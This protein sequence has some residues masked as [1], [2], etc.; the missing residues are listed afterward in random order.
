MRLLLR[1][2][3]YAGQYLFIVVIKYGFIDKWNGNTN[4]RE[5]IIKPVIVAS[6]L[7]LNTFLDQH[8]LYNPM[9]QSKPGF[10]TKWQ[11]FV[12]RNATIHIQAAQPPPPPPQKSI[13]YTPGTA[14]HSNWLQICHLL[15]DWLEALVWIAPH[16]PTEW[17]CWG[18]PRLNSSLPECLHFGK[19]YTHHTHTH[20]PHTLSAL[21]TV[22]FS[23]VLFHS[24]NLIYVS[25][26]P[27]FQHYIKTHLK[28]QINVLL[29]KISGPAQWVCVLWCNFSQ[30]REFSTNFFSYWEK[31]HRN[32]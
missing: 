25:G 5:F 12:D 15:C 13:H 21:L 18:Q 24:N 1:T 3:L 27:V 32:C 29:Y 4:R 11:R 22:V 17:Y 9:S 10:K 23:P 31:L 26:V 28:C 19:T 8:P 14:L 2:V 30:L 20:T 16:W 6:L 7:V